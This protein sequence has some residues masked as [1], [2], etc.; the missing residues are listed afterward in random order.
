MLRSRP[1]LPPVIPDDEL[2]QDII[3]LLHENEWL[4]RHYPDININSIKAMSQEQLFELRS[5]MKTKLG[6]RPFKTKILPYL[7]DM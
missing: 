2:E 3:F 1:S 5:Q 7:G 4:G 6:I